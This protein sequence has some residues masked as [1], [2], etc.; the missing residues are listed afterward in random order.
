MHICCTYVYVIVIR[1]DQL[2]T[3]TSVSLEYCLFCYPFFRHN[4]LDRPR[5]AKLNKTSTTSISLESLRS[6]SPTS[7]GLT[8][9]TSMNESSQRYGI[10]RE[11]TGATSHLCLACR[12]AWRL[13]F[14]FISFYFFYI[15][16]LS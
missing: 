8:L 3:T 1:L 7:A 4:I 14:C 9:V 5:G 11:K 15:N 10:I 16:I 12:V 13:F 2:C 6:H